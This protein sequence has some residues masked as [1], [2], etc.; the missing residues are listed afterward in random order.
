[1]NYIVLDLEAT[2]WEGST[3]HH[4]EIIEIGA[5]LVNEQKETVSEF[6]QFVKPLK[7]PR[8]SDFCKELTSIRQNDVDQAPYFGEALEKFQTWIGYGQEEYVLCSWGFY[9]KKQFESDCQLHGLSTGWLE[10]HISLKHQYA[11]F[12]KLRRAIGMKNALQNENMKLTGTHHRGIDDARNI[13]NIF[14]KYFE[15]W[16]MPG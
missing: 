11:K 15:Q 3:S 8:L 16:K 6:V 2:C 4:N 14:I 7:H 9:D 13:A 5:V 12:K 1:M 10:N